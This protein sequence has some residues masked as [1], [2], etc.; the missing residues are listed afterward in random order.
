MAYSDM[1]PVWVKCTHFSG[2]PACPGGANTEE[3]TKKIM[4]TLKILI[5]IFLACI[6]GNGALAESKA[7]L[8]AGATQQVPPLS[9]TEHAAPGKTALRIVLAKTDGGTE[10]GDVVRAGE[11]FELS[12]ASPSDFAPVR[13]AISMDKAFRPNDVRYSADDLVHPVGEG[14]QLDKNELPLK[15][16][17]ETGSRIATGA[18]PGTDLGDRLIR[19]SA[20]DAT[21]ASRTSERKIS[22][23]SNLRLTAYF[24][25]YERNAYYIGS[26]KDKYRSFQ[27]VPQKVYYNDTSSVTVYVDEQFRDAVYNDSDGTGEGNGRIYRIRKMGDPADGGRAPNPEEEHLFWNSMKR[28]FEFAQAPKLAAPELAFDVQSTAR[29]S[30]EVRSFFNFRGKYRI[31]GFEK[32]FK[33]WAKHRAVDFE[34]ESH[35]P[36]EIRV[37]GDSGRGSAN[38][39]DIYF[40]ETNSDYGVDPEFVDAF[41]RI[42]YWHDIDPNA[43]IGQPILLRA[44]E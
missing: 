35:P 12:V 43:E 1:A 33:E 24:T 36:A 4:R 29:N 42:E 16:V 22:I 21:G 31:L 28:R 27:P 34:Y 17:Y 11:V 26:P 39:L 7:T 5:S 15:A 19:V 30:G 25:P 23:V 8:A 40:V 13:F 37:I 10:I 41:G 3:Q 20:F 9:S 6:G 38:W 44:L 18:V 14:V 2:S 32:H